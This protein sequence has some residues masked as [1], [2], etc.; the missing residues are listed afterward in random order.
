VWFV[1]DIMVSLGFVVY[2]IAQLNRIY[3]V[4]F[5]IIVL[6]VGVFTKYI[7]V[8]VI[9]T[10]MARKEVDIVLSR[11]DVRLMMSKQEVLQ[12]NQLEPEITKYK[13]TID[14]SASWDSKVNK[15]LWRMYEVPIRISQLLIVLIIVYVILGM[16]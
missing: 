3:G 11:H 6:V 16:R 5:V 2:T 10:R 1:P 9:K 12:S 13:E 7:N 14:L 15:Y 4:V 8:F